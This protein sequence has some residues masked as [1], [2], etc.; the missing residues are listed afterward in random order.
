MKQ[1][2]DD[3]EDADR[4]ERK[5]SRD[6]SDSDDRQHRKRHRADHHSRHKHKSKKHKKEK[7]KHKKEHKSR[8]EKHKKEKKRKHSPSSSSSA[9]DASDDDESPQRDASALAPPAHLHRATSPTCEQALRARL[10]QQ[11]RASAS[12]APPDSARL[13]ASGLP[14]TTC[15]SRPIAL[16]LRCDLTTGATA[17]RAS[18]DRQRQLPRAYSSSRPRGQLLSRAWTSL[19]SQRLARKCSPSLRPHSLIEGGRHGEGGQLWRMA[20]GWRARRASCSR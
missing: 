4:R 2:G 17:G 8:K 12:Q 1:H 5:R 10:P 16:R 6:D 14:P 20:P 3:E 19:V 11:Q 13:C 15:A 9:S 18:R 7:H